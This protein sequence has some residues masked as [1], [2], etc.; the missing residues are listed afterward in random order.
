MKESKELSKKAVSRAVV[1]KTAQSPGTVYPAV[2][3]TLG[4]LSALAFGLNPLTLGALVVG[5]VISFSGFAGTYFLGKD[6]I[7]GEYINQIRSNIVKRRRAILEGL[8]EELLD[9][10]EF[11]GVDQIRLFKEKYNNLVSILGKKLNPEELTYVRYLTIAEQV[12][13]AGIDNLE[14]A[15][16]ALKSISAIDIDNLKSQI[17]QG[18][19]IHSSSTLA[20]LEERLALYNNQVQ[21]SHELIAQ[22]ESALTQLDH[23]TTK[24]ANIKTNQ[25][26][27]VMDI[28]EAMSELSN[29]IIKADKYSIER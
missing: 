13:L 18:E 28:E 22:N 15:G 20:A 10:E 23:V 1:K 7:A 26:H 21:R 29:L 27:A 16:L 11:R 17:K 5:S 3:A 24:L 4:G 19:H 6:R 8:E 25:S 2:V 14:S 9:L 12:F